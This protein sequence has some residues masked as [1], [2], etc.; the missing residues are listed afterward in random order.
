MNAS[1]KGILAA[2]AGVLLLAGGGGSLAYW[3]AEG[4]VP[5]GSVTSGRLALTDPSGGSW[6]LNGTPAAGTV[7]IVPGD[8]LRYAGSYTVVA[9]GDTLEATIGLSGGAGSGT[10]ADAV[11]TDVDATIDGTPVTTISSADD[12][13]TLE[14]GVDIDFPFG[15]TVDNTT[16]GLTLDLSAVVV[17]ATQTDATP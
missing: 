3:N 4:T 17:T 16:Q 8:E 11:T 13:S 2:G 1:T 5:G 10:L 14:V 15:D 12:G 7:V 6:T 9:E